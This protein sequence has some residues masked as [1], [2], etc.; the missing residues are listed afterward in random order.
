VYIYEAWNFHG[1]ILEETCQS[2]TGR[3]CSYLD[4]LSL[5]EPLKERARI[6]KG[7]FT[8]YSIDDSSLG[9]YE[10]TDPHFMRFCREM[11]FEL[12]SRGYIIQNKQDCFLDLS[13]FPK[14]DKNIFA[15]MNVIPTYQENSLLS[16]QNSLTGPYPITKPREFTVTFQWNSHQIAL[17]PIFQS[18]LMPLYL[19]E[20]Y[21]TNYPAYFQSSSS[22]KNM[23]K[24][25]YLRTKIT[26]ALS[27]TIPYDNLWL[28]GIL[29]GEKGETISK[30]AEQPMKPSDLFA[31]ENDRSFVRYALLK[32]ISDKSVRFPLSLVRG[33]WNKLRQTIVT[34]KEGRFHIK[35]KSGQI[36]QLLTD[37]FTFLGEFKIKQS[38]DAFCTVLRDG[39]IVSSAEMRTGHLEKELARLYS[40]FLT[41]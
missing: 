8:K 9:I 15:E 3:E 29:S 39:A 32:S 30:H 4:I 22:G 31:L 24:W 14:S 20:K 5:V 25:H 37:S 19:R 41:P 35:N 10:D 17:N 11:F 23:L 28:H 36:S 27:N 40:I 12:N 2:F 34:L 26:L 1:K 38:F 13:K 21:G 7:Y 33:E 18:W 16:I 6:E